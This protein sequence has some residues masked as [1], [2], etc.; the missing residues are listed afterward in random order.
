MKSMDPLYWWGA[1]AAIV[2]IGLIAVVVFSLWRALRWL[3]RSL[4]FATRR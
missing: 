1:A 4:A 2:V 3:G